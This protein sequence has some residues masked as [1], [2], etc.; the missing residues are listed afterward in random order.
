MQGCCRNPFFTVVE[1]VNVAGI[2][3]RVP[4]Q[5]RCSCDIAFRV[6]M[7]SEKPENLDLN[8]R[9]W[10]GTLARSVP[11]VAEL[12]GCPPR[13]RRAPPPEHL[14]SLVSR[15]NTYSRGHAHHTS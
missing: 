14:P 9:Q 12:H 1:N 2:T 3:Y 13:A 11:P 7:G 15:G 5:R 10:H 8:F 6:T 4:V